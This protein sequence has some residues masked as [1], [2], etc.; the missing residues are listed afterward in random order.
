MLGNTVFR[1][2]NQEEARIFLSSTDNY[3]DHLTKLD[4]SLY[5]GTSQ[6]ISIKDHLDFL[7]STALGWTPTEKNK[8]KLMIEQYDVV[9]HSLGIVHLLPS[10]IKLIKTNGKDT[11]N[12]HYTR[13]NGI[14][15]PAINGEEIKTDIGTFYHEMFHIFSRHNAHFQDSLY[16]ICNFEKIPELKLSTSLKDI[17][18][19]NPD[20]FLYQHA[21]V[22]NKDGIEFQSVPFMYSGIKQSDIN[23]PV[24]EAL[25]YKLAMLDITTS[26]SSEP[27]MYKT[28]ETNYKERV[29]ANSHYYIHPEEIMAENFRLLLLTYTKNEIKPK[30]TYPL[31]LDRLLSFLRGMK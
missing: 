1:F 11:F 16:G 26:E 9:L 12:A 23:G 25:V 18:T 22:L 6:D 29:M 30:I 3:T 21:V 19:T 15:F 8:L 4:L 20:A 7:K 27:S 10:E 2:L 17:Q 5:H 28:S 24:N 31:A 13:G 14:I